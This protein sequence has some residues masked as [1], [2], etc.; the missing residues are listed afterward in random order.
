MD[1]RTKWL[2]DL[3][4]RHGFVLLEKRT[5]KHLVLRTLHEATGTTHL[6]TCAVS[7]SDPRARRNFEGHLRRAARTGK[8]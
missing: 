4:K 3:L 5:G 1:S 6:F 7:P 8:A 2:H